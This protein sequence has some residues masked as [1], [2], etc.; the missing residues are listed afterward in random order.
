M[1]TYDYIWEHHMEHIENHLK[2]EEY[3]REHLVYL[4]EFLKKFQK[5]PPAYPLP[6]KKKK[7]FTF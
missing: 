5:I 4:Q 1:R 3:I 2:L 7:P 6:Q